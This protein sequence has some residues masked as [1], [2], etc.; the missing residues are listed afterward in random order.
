M[1][2]PQTSI[3]TST[4]GSLARV[5]N[6]RPALEPLTT[7]F[8]TIYFKAN[9]TGEHV[10]LYVANRIGLVKLKTI[11]AQNHTT[12]NSVKIALGILVP[13]I[14]NQIYP[15]QIETDRSSNRRPIRKKAPNNSP[16]CSYTRHRLI[17][18]VTSPIKGKVPMPISSTPSIKDFEAFELTCF[19]EFHPLTP[20]AQPSPSPANPCKLCNPP[21][22]SK[23][24]YQRASPHLLHPPLNCKKTV[25]NCRR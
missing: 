3:S 7:R 20:P 15:N 6:V 5:A 18:S 11:A 24:Q 12:I 17:K 19:P 22:P 10:T 8:V 16:L 1:F 25:Q 14:A 4:P 9:P 23:P 13:I 2:Y 21:K